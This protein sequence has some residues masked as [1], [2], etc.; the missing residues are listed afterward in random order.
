VL[1]FEW[2]KPRPGE[3]VLIHAASGGVGLAAVQLAQRA[4]AVVFATASRAKQKTLRDLGIEHLYDSRSTEFAEQILA[5]TGGA[6]VD[7]VLNSLTN[8]GF[9]AA[10]VK[11]TAVNGRFVE[12][13]KRDIWSREQ[14]AEARPDLGYHILALDDVMQRDPFRIKSML[15]GL[16]GKIGARELAPLPYQAYPLAE[17][18]AA[19]R[20]MQQARHIGKIVLCMPAPLTLARDRS[21]LITGGLGA[22]GLRTA[23]YFAQLGAGH[24]VLTSRRAPNEAA[25]RTIDEI[26]AQFTCRIDVVCADVSRE[27]DV[28][29]LLDGI[30]RDLPPLAGVAHLAGVLDD[31]LVPQQNAAK[32]EGVLGPKA[33]GAWHLH[34]LTQDDAL[35]FFLLYSSASGVLG[36]PGQANYASA[37]AFLDG[38]AAH[39]RAHGAPAASINWGPWGE[40]GMAAGETA[41]G[42]LGKQGLIPLKPAVALSAL[43][44]M[45]SHGSVQ[46]TVISANWQRAAKLFGPARPPILEHVLPKA[47]NKAGDE[48]LRRQLQQVPT[49]QRGAF[50]T[51]H[52]Q[53]ELQQ[54]LGLAQPPAPE[55][56]FLELGMDSLMAVELRNRLLAQF[57]SGFTISSTVVFDY[58]TIRA[59]AEYLAAQM[60]EAAPQPAAAEMRAIPTDAAA[61][62]AC[63]GTAGD[64]SVRLALAELIEKLKPFRQLGV[65]LQIGGVGIDLEADTTRIEQEILRPAP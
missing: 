61:P 10:T 32:I 13:A 8:D 38:L 33:L 47:A 57:G 20:C 52:L 63:A 19:F 17:A 3:R 34:H 31:A 5:D 1:A 39:R 45:V 53:R 49:A 59:L 37:N 12:I 11:A 15:S 48:A 4:G 60:P 64:D 44:E 29:D 7:V 55:S 27:R 50:L 2:A 23:A 41:R 65:T 22:L 21:Y 40:A 51:E 25:R 30:R 14:M 43:N 54:I 56:R 42:H 35:D 24:L 46:A 58:P 9:V 28:A 36:S 6:G 26:A 18:R 16:A 62:A